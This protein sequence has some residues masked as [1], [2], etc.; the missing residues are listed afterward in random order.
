MKTTKSNIGISIL[1]IGTLLFISVGSICDASIL[2]ENKVYRQ[3]EVAIHLFSMDPENPLDSYRKHGSGRSEGG[4]MGTTCGDKKSHYEVW[5]SC[6]FNK[7]SF[8]VTVD[9]KPSKKNKNPDLY[10]ETYELDCTNLQPKSLELAKGENGRVF[11]LNLVPSIEIIDNRPKRLDDSALAFDITRWAMAGSMVIFN[12]SVYAGQLGC[13]GGP[14]AWV[15]Y[16]G[17]AKVEFS[18]VPFRGAKPIG[19]LKDGRIQIRNEDGQILDIYNVK[20]GTHRVEL[21]GGPYEVWVRWE[22]LPPADPVEIPP[23]EEWI[24]MVRAKFAELGNTPPSDEE[25]DA[26]YERIKHEKHTALSSGVGPIWKKDRI[27]K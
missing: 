2:T 26:G 11:R 3:Y 10:K 12:D 17:Y 21:P 23:K 15:S 20:N 1:L 8:V 27:S 22:N 13:V 25:L 6:K 18:L 4:K 5:T 24:C 16:P 19:I 14:M 9:V 7:G